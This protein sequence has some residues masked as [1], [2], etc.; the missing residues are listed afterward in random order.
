MRVYQVI[1]FSE[2]RSILHR[3]GCGTLKRMEERHSPNRDI[4]AVHPI[5]VLKHLILGAPKVHSCL[6][7][8]DRFAY[9]EMID[10]LV[11]EANRAA[12][13]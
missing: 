7:R 3:E 6:T 5:V 10:D 2:G 13:W 9:I 11:E 8:K 12:R 4:C 1:H